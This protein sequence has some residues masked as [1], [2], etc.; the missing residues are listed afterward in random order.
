MKSPASDQRRHPSE[1]ELLSCMDSSSDARSQRAVIEHLDHCE[2]CQRRIESL[3]SQDQSSRRI[4]SALQAE[5]RAV[6]SSKSDAGTFTHETSPNDFA[7]NFLQPSRRGD[8]IGTIGDFDVLS[9]IGVGGMGLVLKGFDAELNRPV[10]IKVMSP[11]LAAMGVARQRFLREAQATAAIV[12]PNVMPVLSVSESTSSLPFLVMPYVVCHS[13]QQ[14]I[15]A[16]GALPTIDVLRIGTQVA[17]ALAA[18]H[19]QGLVHRDVKPANILLERGVDRAMLTDFGL[20][21]AADDVS[22]TRSG[23]IAGTPQFMSPEQARGEAIDQ[24][25]DLFSLGSVIYT[26]AVGQPPFRSETS[27]GVLRKIIESEP[28]SL[29]EANPDVPEWLETLTFKLLSKESKQRFRSAAEV[30][31]MLESC[32]AHVQ[33]PTVAKLPESLR[34]KKRTRSRLLFV[35]GSALLLFWGITMGAFLLYAMAHEDPQQNAVKVTR[36]DVGVEAEISDPLGDSIDQLEIEVN[37]LRREL[38]QEGTDQWWLSETQPDN[39]S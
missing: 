1:A 20:A 29:R 27:Y 8:A 37:A 33:Q 23:F 16:E 12:H 31:S 6:T 25:S 11:H 3:S 22:V 5:T 15:D 4:V 9:V 19:A 36:E 38:E 2:S 24:R 10:A 7:V 21:R 13:L 26:M 14:R 39:Q 32:L 34:M 18:A 30:Q 28:K 35:F 17:A